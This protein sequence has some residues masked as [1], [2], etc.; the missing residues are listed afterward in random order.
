MEMKTRGN[1]LEFLDALQS[2]SRHNDRVSRCF[3]SM[4][5]WPQLNPTSSIYNH[6]I[7][8]SQVHYPTLYSFHYEPCSLTLFLTHIR[9]MIPCSKLCV[10][11]PNSTP[12][13]IHF[14][15]CTYPL[16]N[17]NFFGLLNPLLIVR[18]TF[19]YPFRFSFGFIFSYLSQTILITSILLQLILN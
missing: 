11:P 19:S 18:S 5:P 13:M 7:P 14:F 1:L 15:I 4:K 16:F 8:K 10:G 2:Q 3:S 17:L 9:F 12:S 6:K